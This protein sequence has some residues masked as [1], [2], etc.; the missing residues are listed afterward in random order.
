[1][2]EKIAADLKTAM[3]AGERAKVDAL[4]L[5]NAALKDKDIEARG[6]GK[7]LSGDDELALLQKMI[8]SRQESL[9]IYEK[10]GRE[11][12]AGKERGEI[13][14]IS[15]YLPQQLSEAEAAEA[16][17]AAIDETGAASIKDMGKVVA[18]LKAK[19]TGRMDFGKASAAVKAALSG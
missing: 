12:L 4:R 15:A 3:K 5:I 10:A 17:K 14:V 9:E 1:M 8:K 19:Y 2:R 16:V 11:D 7:T 13:A 6:A 18:A